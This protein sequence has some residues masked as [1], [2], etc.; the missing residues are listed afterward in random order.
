LY[1]PLSVAGS[2]FEPSPVASPPAGHVE[3]G[4]KIKAHS[5]PLI[6][7]P[8]HSG[9]YP[10]PPVTEFTRTTDGATLSIDESSMHHETLETLQRSTRLSEALT[11][12]EKA[13]IEATLEETGG[14]V[15]GPSGAA[16]KLGIPRYTLELK[17]RILRINKQL[18]RSERR[19]SSTG[20][21]ASW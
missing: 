3:P 10:I 14:R 7:F 4:L 15:S 20:D 17:I 11:N 18:F 19:H 8:S 21:V 2:V 5:A 13:M 1:I 9:Q 12:T 6:C 16:V